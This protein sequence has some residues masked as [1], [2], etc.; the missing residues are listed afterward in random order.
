MFAA[1]SF[2]VGAAE[3]EA[4]QTGFSLRSFLWSQFPFTSEAMEAFVTAYEATE[5][6]T[7]VTYALD[8]K[9]EKE[10][11]PTTPEEHREYINVSVLQD[12]AWSMFKTVFVNTVTPHHKN[13]AEGRAEAE[14]WAVIKAFRALERERKE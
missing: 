7:R 14:E 8:R 9:T 4:L 6:A 5:I 1:A 11:R 13:F 2:L 12:A 3:K 10:D